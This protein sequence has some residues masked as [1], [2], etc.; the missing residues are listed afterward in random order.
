MSKAT[1]I[2][3][4]KPITVEP[5]IVAL[6]AIT[7]MHETEADCLVVT[8]QNQV[9][10][11]FTERDAIKAVVASL[12]LMETE[13]TA[14]M[15]SPV[16]TLLEADARDAGTVLR[17]MQQHHLRYLLVVNSCGE[18]ISL[19]TETSLQ[20]LE[21][22]NI[23]ESQQEL[24]NKYCSL[25][26]HSI[27]GI[28]QVSANGAYLSVNPTLAKMHGYGSP[29]EMMASIRDVNQQIYVDCTR[30]SE[31]LNLIQENGIVQGFETQVY[32]KDGS[33]LWVSENVWAI[34]DEQGNLLYYEGA[35]I[36]I[37]DHKRSES[38][39]QQIEQELQT[40]TERFRHIYENAPIMMHLI[41]ESGFI[42]DVNR[43]WLEETGYSRE[44]VIGQNFEFLMTPDSAQKFHSLVTQ[45]WRDCYA[46]DVTYQYICKDGRIIDVILNC[47]VT[48]TPEGDR[49]C[50]S[51]IQNVTEQRQAES[52][53]QQLNTE[54]E[55]R[56]SQRT[57]ELTATVEQ[58]QQEILNRQRI[59]ALFLENEARFHQLAASVPGM[60]Y[61]YVWYPDNSDALIY[62]SPACQDIYEVP[63]EKV[64]E[65]AGF[66]WE[67]FPPE[68][69]QHVQELFANSFETLEPFQVECQII[70][71]GHSKWIQIN[72]RPKRHSDESVIW[73][74]I[75]IDITEG[76]QTRE[77]LQ[78]S[79]ARFQK[80]AENVPGMLYQYVLYPDGSDA[81]TYV[82]STCQDIYEIPVEAAL[83]NVNLLWELFHPDD[84][85]TARRATIASA[86]TLEPWYAK[87]RILTP[88][89]RLKW[90]QG[91]SHPTRGHDGSVV[92]DGI[93]VDI[94]ER[95]QAEEALRQ[96]EERF[97]ALFEQAGIGINLCDLPG[98][99]L[100]VNQAFCNL[101]G[102]TGAELLQMSHWDLTNPEDLEFCQELNRQALVDQ[103]HTYSL[104][105]R[106]Q[107][108][109][110]QMVWAN[111]HVTKVYSPQGELAF[112]SAI[113]EDITERKRAEEALQQSEERLRLVLQKMPIMMDVF[114]EENNIIVW[115]QECERVTGYTAD[116]IINNPKAMELLYPDPDYLQS[117]TSEW[118]KRGYDYRN[119]E[120][121]VTCKD[122]TVKTI[123]W[124]NLSGEFPI[125]GWA[126]WSFGVDVSER[127]RIEAE[128]LNA[129]DQERKLNELKSQFISM[130]SHEFRTPLST[131]LSSTELLQKYGQQWI[132][133]KRQ[134]R[135][136]RI[137][138]AI[139]RMTELLNDVL[140]VGKAEA[141]KLQFIPTSIDLV[142]F[143]HELL[144]EMQLNIQDR[145]VLKFI[146]EG[147]C[148]SFYLDKQLLR[149]ILINLVSNA[150][151]YSPQ[152]G[153]IYLRLRCEVQEVILQVQDSGI[154]IPAE[155]QA[156]LFTI[157]KR[158]NN[159]GTIPGTG[160]GLAL[161]K[162]CVDLQDGT[163]AVESELGK[164]TLITVKLP[165]RQMQQSYD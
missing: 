91:D 113:V 52:A 145:H 162:Q 44:E 148:G 137:V 11:I 45:F 79:E 97:R 55:A 116:E 117:M 48:T 80:L 5:N 135:L 35:L 14:V 86:Q 65:S 13:I 59:E 100:R 47:I 107:H 83:Q 141:G 12:N 38:E 15:T 51:V 19:I 46:K 143:C 121:N 41:D 103:T 74:G 154:G 84:L 90:L 124:S 1:S 36:D 72:S 22:E 146:Y 43:K 40:S 64:L 165:S 156:E 8:H 77:A 120:W 16:I 61:Q 150:I 81:L 63:P 114:D 109:H 32:R 23:L 33:T 144:E 26:E 27:E 85:E 93:M 133:E 49:V 99:F 71:Q 98:R 2:R 140:L 153:E 142:N 50:L 163:I 151:K 28:F 158:G 119:W 92:W 164:G 115:N 34:R 101:V 60:I 70:V 6:D 66:M 39:C 25:F 3:G 31:L 20:T 127:K 68:E 112:S 147:C 138:K 108:K 94:T 73:I 56:I 29:Q 160:L 54:L 58:L 111:V 18:V 104:E 106:Y 110:G 128:I 82:S 88:S 118:S 57:I 76:K 130:V 53:L 131:I 95:Q 125:S 139:D 24:E 62:V 122:G 69:F 10:G 89:G 37:S 159:V 30:R 87:Y 161:V 9:V 126:C 136:R 102:Y 67:L 96:S 75:V 129:L 78:Q 123:A 134:L 7:L 132:E 42:C 152:G 155:D 157:F 149:H 4:I 21:F 17:F 105:K